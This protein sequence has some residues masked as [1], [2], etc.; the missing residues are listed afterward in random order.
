MNKEAAEMCSEIREIGR[1]ISSAALIM[2]VRKEVSKVM[3]D[4]FVVTDGKHLASDYEVVVK[5]GKNAE[6]IS[7][8]LRDG[9]TNVDVDH[10]A[11]GVL[12]IKTAR[13]SKE[14]L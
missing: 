11:E 13:R 14:T 3:K 1:L 6:D 4:G 2:A 5:C 8:R 9:V 7:R 10:I 12:G